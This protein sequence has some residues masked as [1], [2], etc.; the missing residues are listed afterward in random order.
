MID[1]EQQRQIKARKLER[2]L[3][4]A[5]EIAICKDFRE[6]ETRE[7]SLRIAAIRAKY[8]QDYPTTSSKE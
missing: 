5:F 8:Q 3:D 4:E 7:R 6:E 1:D 2:E